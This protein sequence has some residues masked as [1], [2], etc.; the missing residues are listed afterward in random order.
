MG[1][2]GPTAAARWTPWN[3]D[4]L[5]PGKGRWLA[6]RPIAAV[7]RALL[8]MT[9]VTDIDVD[10]S[11]IPDSRAGFRLIFLPSRPELSME[12]GPQEALDAIRRQLILLRAEGCEQ[13]PDCEECGATVCEIVKEIRV[14]E[15]FVR[16][17]A[18]NRL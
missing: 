6:F 7:I 2:K 9:A 10:R 8:A 4:R 13:S 17:S 3:A 15:A 16:D 1:D 5:Q 18:K 14:L 12:K 11:T